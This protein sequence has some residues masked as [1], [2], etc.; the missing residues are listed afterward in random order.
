MAP[1]GYPSTVC[2]TVSL[3]EEISKKERKKKKGERKINKKSLLMIS[4]KWVEQN[5]SSEKK[6]FSV[7]QPLQ[8][9]EHIQIKVKG[10]K[11]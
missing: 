4:V 10:L 9:G 2:L 11:L 3:P 6:I 7:S 1:S 5:L 8:F